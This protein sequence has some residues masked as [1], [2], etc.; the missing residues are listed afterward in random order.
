MNCSWAREVRPSSP[1]HETTVVSSGAVAQT[2]GS[3]ILNC[4]IFIGHDRGQPIQQ[5]IK[6][7]KLMIVP[8]VSATAPWFFPIYELLF[9]FIIT[10]LFLNISSWK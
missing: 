4:V 2:V 7:T 8:T 3:T 5:P 10:L 9:D 1:P 6:K